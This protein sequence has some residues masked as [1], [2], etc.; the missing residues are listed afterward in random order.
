MQK[1]SNTMKTLSRIKRFKQR[2]RK[3]GSYVKSKIR[4]KYT[5]IAGLIAICLSRYFTPVISNESKFHPPIASD[6]ITH[7]RQYDYY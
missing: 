4:G 6:Q 1:R 7:S 2:A 5:K 3:L